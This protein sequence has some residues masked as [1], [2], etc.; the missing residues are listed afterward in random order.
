MVR[1]VSLKI[2]EG[3]GQVS[4]MTRNEDLSVPCCMAVTLLQKRSIEHVT[5]DTQEA[6]TVAFCNQVKSC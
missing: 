3:Q 2:S 4:K 1:E 6:K 5:K